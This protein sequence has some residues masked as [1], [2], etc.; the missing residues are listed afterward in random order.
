MVGRQ[1]PYGLPEPVTRPSMY[2]AYP[3]T[4]HRGSL[5]G[6]GPR[7]TGS[8]SQRPRMRGFREG[9]IRCARWP[10]SC[11]ASMS[12]HVTYVPTSSRG[13]GGVAQNTSAG[14]SRNGHA[15][16]LDIP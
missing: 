16:P 3:S 8:T 10:N 11:E 15:D 4:T 9:L 12:A 6:I 14:E 5:A 13:L 7:F 1:V 2:V